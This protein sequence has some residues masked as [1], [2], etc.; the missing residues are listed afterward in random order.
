VRI[1]EQITEC[2]LRAQQLLTGILPVL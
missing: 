2:V 1:C